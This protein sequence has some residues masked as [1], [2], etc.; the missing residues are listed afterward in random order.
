ML[1]PEINDILR[2]LAGTDTMVSVWTRGIGT[3][4]WVGKIVK[5]QYPLV[6]MEYDGG[7][8]TGHA[9]IPLDLVEVVTYQDQTQEQKQQEEDEDEAQA[10]AA[11]GIKSVLPWQRMKK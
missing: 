1:R 8:F 11:L 6:E 7:S 5:V 9:F 2:G 4:R 3:D 10:E